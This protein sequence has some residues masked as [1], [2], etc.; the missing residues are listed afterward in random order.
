MNHDSRRVPGDPLSTHERALL[1]LLCS[2]TWHGTIEARRQ[3]A[4][5][6][7]GGLEFDDCECFLV[8]VPEDLDLPRIPKR[9]GGPFSTVEVHDGESA[10]GH[11]NLWSVDGLLHSVDYM[12]FDAPDEHLPAVE[13]LGDGPFKG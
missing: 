3:L 1:E 9:S 8:V 13:L 10:L 5:A 4:H 11:L 6:R 7:W 12:T 2:G